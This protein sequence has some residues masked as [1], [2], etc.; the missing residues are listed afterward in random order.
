[1][2]TSLL[3]RVFKNDEH[4]EFDDTSYSHEDMDEAFKLAYAHIWEGTPPLSVDP[5][6]PTPQRLDTPHGFAIAC[7]GVWIHSNVAELVGQ[8]V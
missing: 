3:V 1:M 8:A 6:P 2:T 5:E 4:T 7:D